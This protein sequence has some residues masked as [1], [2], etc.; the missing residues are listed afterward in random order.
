MIIPGCKYL[1][2][3]S[4]KHSFGAVGMLLLLAGFLLESSLFAATDQVVAIFPLLDLSKGPNGIN[5]TISEHTLEAIK[6]QG[7]TVID[8]DRLMGFMVRHRIRTLSHLTSY[9][10][11]LLKKELDADLVILGTI[12]ELK[13]NPT[14]AISISLQLIRSTDAEIVW[15]RTENLYYADLITL[16]GLHD[17]KTLDDLY[18]V[19]FK[20]LFQGLPDLI[21]TADAP[22]N[23]LDVATVI[24]YPNHVRPDEK[25]NC[26][27][28]LHTPIGVGDNRPLILARVGEDEYPLTLDDDGYYFTAMWS[29]S[30]VAGEKNVSLW[31]KWPDGEEVE[32]RI[33]TYIVDDHPP[34]IELH[35]GAKEING[36]PFFN[37]KLVIVPLLIDPEPITRW[38]ITVIN[39]QGETIVRQSAAEHIP[40][41]LTWSGQTTLGSSAF[42]GDY[43][44]IF[45][46]WDRAGWSATA[47]TDVLLKRQVPEISLDVKKDKETMNITLQ[48]LEVNQLEFWWARF[49]AEDGHLITVAEGETMPASVVLDLAGDKPV[50]GVECIVVAQDIYGNRIKKD[51]K[52]LGQLIAPEDQGDTL[53][54]TEWVE[55]F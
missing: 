3:R 6:E 32:I 7:Y 1:R 2:R 13:E 30:D 39:E 19:F 9:Q 29:A 16:L 54:E 5:H 27:I 24:L 41:R 10:I 46:V 15:A 28:K 42:D 34:K 21:A 25:V 14:P 45:K 52:N 23:K 53:Q 37:N 33:G 55:E 8:Q 4:G 12:S 35:L 22:E 11:S 50:Q 48:N 40:R 31:G 43:H 36:K 47:E 26:R 44:I 18:A 51:I 17:P 38:E 49:F 20:K